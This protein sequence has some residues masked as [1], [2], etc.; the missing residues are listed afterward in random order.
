MLA[1]FGNYAVPVTY[2]G[3]FTVVDGRVVFTRRG[4]VILPNSGTSD[5]EAR[6]DVPNTG[7]PDPN[8]HTT[9][10]RVIVRSPDKKQVLLFNRNSKWSFF[11]PVW[12]KEGQYVDS[13]TAGFL[14]DKLKDNRTLPATEWV[15]KKAADGSSFYILTTDLSSVTPVSG[16]TAK[17][18]AEELKAVAGTVDPLVTAEV[19]EEA[20][21]SK[22]FFGR[23]FSRIMNA[24]GPGEEVVNA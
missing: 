5:P 3:P 14:W 4:P 20:F 7:A 15:E 22:G 11:Y 23:V 13:K 1:R 2:T 17:L 10:I 18:T 12:A 21:E 8:L 6:A 16:Q 24:D 19:L 9:K